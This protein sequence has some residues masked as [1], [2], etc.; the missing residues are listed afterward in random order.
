M[1]DKKVLIASLGIALGV[2]VYFCLRRFGR[3]KLG[4][5]PSTV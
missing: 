5:L 3:I 1:L 2:G 4:N